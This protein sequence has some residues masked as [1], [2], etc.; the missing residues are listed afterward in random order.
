MR[1]GQS[2]A[3]IFGPLQEMVMELR[4][5]IRPVII[6][7]ITKSD[8]CAAGVP[9]YELLITDGI[10]QHEVLMSIHHK[11]HNSQEKKNRQVMKER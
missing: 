11:N 1:L 3:R 9:E 5:P 6:R 2:R 7:A 4:S 10:G 8:G